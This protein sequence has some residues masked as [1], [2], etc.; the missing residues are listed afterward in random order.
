VKSLSFSEFYKGQFADDGFEL[1]LLKDSDENVLYIGISKDSIW[2]RWFGGGTSH[3]DIDAAG[4]I[5]GKSHIGEAIEKCFPSSWNW[6]IELWTR[7]DCLKACKSEFSK[8]NVNK[9]GI[10]LI[11]PYMIAKF[12]PLYNVIHNRRNYENS[13]T[14]ND[15]DSVTNYSFNQA[16]RADNTSD[17]TIA[18]AET[19]FLESIGLPGSANSLRAYRNAL[20]SFSDML[21]SQQIDPSTFPV[22]KLK[23][24]LISDFADYMKEF[25]PSTESLY[26]QVIKSFLK[27]LDAAN[28]LT[29]D[30]SH[31][32]MLIRQR[33]RR[34]RRQPAEYPEEDVKRLIEFMSNTQ[35]FPAL[36]EDKWDN[37]ALRDARDRAL[38]LTLADTGLRVD[39]ICSV[40][41]SDIDWGTSQTTLHSRGKKQTFVRFSTRSINAIKVYLAYRMQ[42]ALG[43][44]QPTSPIPLFARHDKGAGKKIKPVTPMTIQ[45]IVS[46]RVR[47]ALG[48]EAIGSITPHT[49]LH[50]FVTTILRATGNLKLAQVLARH[51]NIQIT[52][53][54]AHISDHELNQSYSEIFDS[55]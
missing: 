32:R 55:L 22:V 52:Q 1:Y 41:C 7:E 51:A 28:L 44:S 23:E 15:L 26:L 40:R 3:M 33:T 47:Q 36:Y 37:V 27:F 11:E 25:A 10:E 21:A 17:I 18:Q 39:E 16:E 12:E 54:Y 31:V 43:I 6:V 9:V 35:N 24:N 50:Y 46:E 53:K 48:P 42:L 13:A 14:S 20:E 29:V 5:C 38:I 8:R 19:M 45:R 4:K 49:F 34:S 30:P 2:H